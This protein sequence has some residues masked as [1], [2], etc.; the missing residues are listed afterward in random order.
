MR[1]PITASDFVADQGVTR[2]IVRHAQQS[3]GQTHQRGALLARERVF[4]DQPL[5]P[6]ALP[7][8]PEASDQI[9][10]SPGNFCASIRGQAGRLEQRGERVLLT[11]AVSSSDLAA[12][13]CRGAKG[14]RKIGKGFL[15][16]RP[17]HCLVLRLH[18]QKLA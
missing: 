17:W 3:L 5:D 12:Q 16:L 11:N 15:V 18:H 13:F 7:L 6:A 8:G 14:V 9:S 1:A 10:R 2:C 4:L